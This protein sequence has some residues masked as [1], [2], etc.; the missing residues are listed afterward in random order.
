MWDRYFWAPAV[1]LLGIG[2]SFASI[3]AAAVA[4]TIDSD[5]IG[6]ASVYLFAAGVISGG[7]GLVSLP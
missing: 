2:L 3:A 5:G 1:C 4:L 7:I 6:W